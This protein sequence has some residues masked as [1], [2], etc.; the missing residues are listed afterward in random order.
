[1]V[2]LHERILRALDRAPRKTLDPWDLASQTGYLPEVLKAISM[3]QRQ[4]LIRVA[5]GAIRL[6]ASAL[7]MKPLR[8]KS[9]SLDRVMRRY[10]D[11]R[12]R[13]TFDQHAFDQLCLSP[14]AV[15]FKLSRAIGYDDL[16][17]KDV[18]CVG[19][20]D[21][22]SVA[23]ALTGLPRSITVVEYDPK[24]IKAIRSVK[25]PVKI[26][27]IRANLIEALPKQLKNRFD[28]VFTEPPDKP[29]GTLL[30]L[31]RGVEALRSDGVA[32]CGMPAVTLS[33]RQWRRVQE[34][35]TRAGFAITDGWRD[36]EPYVV[37]G[38]ETTWY[39][40]ENIPDWMKYIPKRS[41]FISTLFRFE[42][43]AR[44][45]LPKI[46]IQDIKREL[47]TNFIE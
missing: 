11:I 7:V 18:L 4:G 12:S 20:D 27:V 16:F 15:A 5:R 28:V 2:W 8:K 42:R 47:L 13:L 3:L 9:P 38:D 14:K 19:D 36:A 39:G 25:T 43:V 40:F 44:K 30:F 6:T 35:M 22:F 34:M 33:L 23:I 32:Y 45:P 26:R 41:W 1:M 21:L 17:G 29:K 31:S 46:R 10:T 37:G 24:V